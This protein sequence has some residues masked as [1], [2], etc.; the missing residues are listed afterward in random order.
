MSKQKTIREYFTEIMETYDLSAEHKE[1]IEKRLSALDKK[2]TDRKPT[3]TQIANENLAN[4]VYEQMAPNTLYTVSQMM[5]A[6][7]AFA[8]IDGLS[9]SKANSIVKKLKDS[10]RV[11]R[12]ESKGVAYFEKVVG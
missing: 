6:I 1:F 9:Q 2:T 8:E 11:A 5:K 10:G 4:A 7:P 12:T 3:A